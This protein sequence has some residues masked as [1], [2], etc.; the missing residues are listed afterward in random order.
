MDRQDILLS[1]SDLMTRDGDFVIDNS[2]LQNIYLIIRLHP[3]NIKQYPLIGV[4]E[5]RF[6]NGTVDGNLRRE[7]QLQLESD[8][9]RPR[10]LSINGAQIDVEL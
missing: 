9:Y 5:E 8:G 6:L 1:D 10:K 7:L 3:G 4:G 2:D